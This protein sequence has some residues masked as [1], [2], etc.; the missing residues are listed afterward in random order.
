MSANDVPFNT[1]EQ[2]ENDLDKTTIISPTTECSISL[3]LPET[4]NDEFK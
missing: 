2:D 1:I 3:L 4:T